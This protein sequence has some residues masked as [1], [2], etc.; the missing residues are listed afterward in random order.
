[1]GSKQK[2]A[3]HSAAGALARIAA[4]DASAKAALLLALRNGKPPVREVAAAGLAKLDTASNDVATALCDALSDGDVNVRCEAAWALGALSERGFAGDVPMGES[5]VKLLG[6]ADPALRGAAAWNLG[7]LS[8][9][10]TA[11]P[12]AH[13]ALTALIADENRGV[14]CA[15]AA[16]L[17]QHA[18]DVAR[19]AAAAMVDRPTA[20]RA[21]LASAAI[22]D[23]KQLVETALEH[24]DE[25]LEDL[26]Y[27]RPESDWASPDFW[28]DGRSRVV[29]EVHARWS[30]SPS[31]LVRFLTAGPERQRGWLWKRLE[32]RTMD[33]KETWSM[34]AVPLEDEGLTDSNAERE[35]R[36]ILNERAT[37][38]LQELQEAIEAAGLDDVNQF[39]YV[40]KDHFRGEQMLREVKAR[41]GVKLTHDGLRGR[42]KRVK[43]Q[44]SEALSRIR[45]EPV[46]DTSDSSDSSDDD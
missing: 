42:R 4:R 20:H 15:A 10:R 41:Y 12:Q 28:H 23:F 21:L 35:R 36:R 7:R 29:S 8:L 6:D 33:V 45:G 1:V 31:E 27:D 22:G 44:V 17:A 9:A 43:A 14:S 2:A 13:A 40:M 37:A 25:T 26:V 30:A 34:P 3:A 19:S 38:A 16:A 11:E 24:A 39:I 18:P 32:W 46:R 5:L